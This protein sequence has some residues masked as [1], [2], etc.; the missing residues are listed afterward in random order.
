M[1]RNGVAVLRGQPVLLEFARGG[2][3]RTAV[4]QHGSRLNR[5]EIT[6]PTEARA[7]LDYDEH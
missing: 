7:K 4:G 3:P 6:D 5:A 1:F 2:L